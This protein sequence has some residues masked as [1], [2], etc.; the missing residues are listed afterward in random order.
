[1]SVERRKV[2]ELLAQGKINADE[3]EKLL[4][5][6]DSL[7]GGEAESYVPEAKTADSRPLR[8]L[9]VEVEKP[10]S[11][12]N[13]NVRIPLSFLRA[14][15]GLHVLLPQRVLAALNANGV[16]IENLSRLRSPELENVLKEL[17]VHVDEGNGKKV[18]VFCE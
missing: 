7:S 11:S 6:L 2:L 3:A 4:N 16:D 14:S 1:M 15:S 10:G 12:E 9:R 17:D 18:R 5:K 13:V 8:Y